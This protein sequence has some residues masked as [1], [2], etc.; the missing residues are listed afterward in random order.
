MNITRRRSYC[1]VT[2]QECSTLLC[3]LTCNAYTVNISAPYRTNYGVAPPVQYHSRRTPILTLGIVRGIRPDDIRT[4]IVELYRRPPSP[5]HSHG[6]TGAV[7]GHMQVCADI[8]G[9]I[10]RDTG[11]IG[12]VALR[13]LFTRGC[14][15]TCRR[16]R[17]THPHRTTPTHMSRCASTITNGDDEFTLSPST[18]ARGPTTSTP[19]SSYRIDAYH[20]IYT[21]RGQVR[22]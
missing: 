17:S 22:S 12:P 10:I 2:L 20:R 4:I 7:V 5:S 3:E 19:S 21:H 13:R 18:R 1:P 16:T 9:M 6:T 15:T 14:T 11:D 8:T